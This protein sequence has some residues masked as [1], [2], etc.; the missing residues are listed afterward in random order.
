MRAVSRI[1]G[2]H[3]P[4]DSAR[5]SVVVRPLSP[6]ARTVISLTWRWLRG[7]GAVILTVAA[8]EYGILPFVV[9][10]STELSVLADVTSPLLLVAAGLEV[11][12]LAAYTGLTQVLLEPPNRLRFGSQWQ[13]D[14]VGYGLSHALPGGGATA[15]GLRVGLMTDRGVATSAALALTVVQLVLSVLGLLAVWL[16]GTMMSLPRTGVTATTV[17]LLVAASAAVVALEG[18]PR[19]HRSGA[20]RTAGRVLAA[21]RSALPDRWRVVI[22][23]AVGRGIASLRDT[24]ITRAGVTWASVN[25]LL[26]AIC[27]WVCLRAFGASVPVELVLASYGLVNAIA[28]LP[29]TPGGI[30]IVEGLLIPALVAAG[31]PPGTALYG[32]LTWRLLQF[33]L[34]IPAAGVCWASLTLTGTPPRHGPSADPPGPRPPARGPGR[35]GATGSAVARG[36]GASGPTSNHQ[37]KG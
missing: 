14:V 1:R 32:V 16:L 12:S 9:N 10:A 24:R 7:V 18:V 5:L 11:A 6:R 30:G 26:D 8:V 23:S 15:G 34:P 19:L 29:I 37:P 2:E 31:A 22:R 36:R 21:V 27:L 28:L 35:A 25:W 17:L 33:W 3:G 20:R 13:I 4:S